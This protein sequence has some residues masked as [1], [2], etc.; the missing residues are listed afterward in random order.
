MENLYPHSDDLNQ[1]DLGTIP[2]NMNNMNQEDMMQ[3]QYNNMENA[4]QVGIDSNS[5]VVDL[6][7]NLNVRQNQK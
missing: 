3:F 2:R 6:S 1:I 5:K 4:N 7:N